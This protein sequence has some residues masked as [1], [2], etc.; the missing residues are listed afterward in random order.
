MSEDKAVA[1]PKTF[2]F[3]EFETKDKSNQGFEVA[4]NNAFGE[5]SGLFI[6]VLGVDS[7]AYVALKEKHD[8]A[9]V[10]KM[11]KLGRG[12]IEQLYDD[13]KNND[14]ELLV[15]CTLSWRHASK[16][17]MPFAIGPSSPEETKA[18]YTKYPLVAEQVRVGMSDRANF[19]PA[20]ANS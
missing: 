18:F 4:I 3:E 17:N 7:D 12:A 8:R 15:A 6:T 10:K 2:S 16:D 20:S 5:P 13:S 14:I 1:V 9:R 11:A 19:T